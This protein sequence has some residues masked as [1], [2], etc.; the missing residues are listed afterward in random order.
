MFKNLCET[1]IKEDFAAHN[2][3]DAMEQVGCPSWDVMVALTFKHGSDRYSTLI[4]ILSATLSEAAF[5]AFQRKH[6]GMPFSGYDYCMSKLFQFFG[7]T[8]GESVDDDPDLHR[9]ARRE[10]RAALVKAFPPQTPLEVFFTI[11]WDDV[12]T[13]RDQY[14]LFE[15]IERLGQYSD[16][17]LVDVPEPASKPQHQ[18]PKAAPIQ[19]SEFR[20][21]D[22][23]QPDA[24]LTK[25]D[26]AAYIGVSVRQ[27]N[28]AVQH[29]K[30]DQVGM[31]QTKFI[32]V[33]SARRYKGE[34]V[35]K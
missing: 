14:T 22:R 16:V 3:T 8:V 15:L 34:L 21:A 23:L 30:L 35:Q 31:G 18:P 28:K 32:T 7:V 27:I 9:R 24:P 29:G 20:L 33:E 12:F 26:A 25:K 1:A 2:F 6:P 17:A 5:Q 19:S 4:E 11:N 10:F 13:D